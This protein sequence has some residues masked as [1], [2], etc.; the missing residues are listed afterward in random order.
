MTGTICASTAA[1]HI[2]VK[3]RTR[4]E[5]TSRDVGT[6]TAGAPF[7]SGLRDHCFLFWSGNCHRLVLE[8]ASQHW[9]RF[10][11]GGPRDDRLGRRLELSLCQLG[12]IG[13]DGLGWLCLSVR[14]SGD[15]LVLD[16]RHSSHV[17]SRA[18][19][20]AV[21]LHFQDSLGPRIPKIAFRRVK[22]RAVSCFF[23][24]HDGLNERRQHVRDGQ[25]HANCFGMAALVQHMGFIAY[26]GGLCDAGRITLSNL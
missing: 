25:G 19:D 5:S 13:A 16:W 1:R 20:D 26:R 4:N 17:V 10:F 2:T 7:R 12:S 6:R 14:H 3:T 11:H 18:G 9:R 8:R 22:P 21:L 24:F 15:A 23:R